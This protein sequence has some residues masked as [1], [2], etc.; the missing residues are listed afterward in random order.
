MKNTIKLSILA[1][2]ISGLLNAQVSVTDSTASPACH[3]FAFAGP[4]PEHATL[5]KGQ[6]LRLPVDMIG[7]A[8]S[9]TLFAELSNAEGDF[10]PPLVIGSY[11]F[12]RATGPNARVFLNTRIPEELGSSDNYKI[13][14]VDE[15]G[16]SDIIMT[17]VSIVPMYVW[18]A[19][20]DGDGLGDPAKSFVSISKNEPGFVQ[21]AD[22]T[23]DNRVKT[24]SEISGMRK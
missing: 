9:V 4:A 13:R 8:D 7:D 20:F 21:N 15:M 10:E 14:L 22:D 19:D 5:Y 2:G 6:W 11:S 18:Y 16:G 24:G 1:I 12:Q 17:H 23:D 3:G